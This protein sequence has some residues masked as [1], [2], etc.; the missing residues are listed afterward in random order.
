MSALLRPLPLML[1][2]AFG[3]L[4]AGCGSS[5][6]AAETIVVTETVAEPVTTTEPA[7]ASTQAAAAT[8]TDQKKASVLPDLVGERLDVAEG[9][10]DDLGIA[11]Q[12]VG[13]GTFGVVV[14][15]NWS[16]CDQRPKAG[17][18]TRSVKLIVARP[19]ECDESTHQ[20]DTGGSAEALPNLVGQ[21]LDIAEDALEEIAVAYEVIGGGLF[22]VVDHTAWEVC[23]QRPAAGASAQNVELIV[24][25]PGEC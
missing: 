12:E 16:V 8:T 4:L 18:Q 22:G 24:D 23:E 19:G 2:L 20:R 9:A 1:C 13:G 21:R 10:L 7:H 6:Q 11:Y 14:A 15:S 17:S 5:D 25:R 3:L